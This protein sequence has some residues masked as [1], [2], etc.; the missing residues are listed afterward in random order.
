MASRICLLFFLMHFVWAGVAGELGEPVC[1]T[2]EPCD[3]THEQVAD[4]EED[5]SLIQF[6]KVNTSQGYPDSSRCENMLV[7]IPVGGGFSFQSH[8]HFLRIEK[9]LHDLPIPD[10]D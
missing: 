1:Y 6:H 8:Y 7:N 10:Q 4:Q 2:G 9:S 5:S 3:N